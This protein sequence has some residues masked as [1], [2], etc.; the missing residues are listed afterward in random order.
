MEHKEIERLLLENLK[1]SRENREY[2]IKIDRRQRITRALN[3]FY[4]VVII[5]LAVGGYYYAFPY[6]QEFQETFS[7]TWDTV[8]ST[9][10]LTPFRNGQQ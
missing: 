1:L 7:Q 2:I 6:L 4:W 3:T 5:G 9:V 10:S 8:S